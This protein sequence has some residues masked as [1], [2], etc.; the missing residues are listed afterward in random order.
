MPYSTGQYDNLTIWRSAP[1]SYKRHFIRMIIT[2]H[3]FAYCEQNHNYQICSNVFVGPE[4]SLY[5]CPYEYVWKVLRKF[6][7]TAQQFPNS[8]PKYENRKIHSRLL[9]VQTFIF[10]NRPA[11]LLF[12]WNPLLDICGMGGC[13][14]N[15]ASPARG[16]PSSF[17][18]YTFGYFNVY[19]RKIYFTFWKLYNYS[20]IVGHQY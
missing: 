6:D 13:T 12:Y 19:F 3:H 7:A 8:L 4:M 1:S 14:K 18:I 10:S 5:V 17:D 20:W 2:L 15:W 16:L 11:L 9:V